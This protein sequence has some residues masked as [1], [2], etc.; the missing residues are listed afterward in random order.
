MTAPLA[1]VVR[2]NTSNDVIYGNSGSICNLTELALG[3]I[4]S[5]MNR[6]SPFSFFGLSLMGSTPCL[7]RDMM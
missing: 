4:R 3:K 5:C 6:N 1:S 7:E 2:H